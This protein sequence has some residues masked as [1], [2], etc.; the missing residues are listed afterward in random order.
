MSSLSDGLE[1]QWQPSRW[2]LAGYGGFQLLALLSLWQ[3]DL[4]LWALVLG[5]LFCVAHALWVVPRYLSLSSPFAY[6]GLR[7]SHDGWQVYSRAAGW[8]VIEL[9]ADSLALPA[10]ILLRFRLLGQ[11][12]VR[13]LCIARD[14]LS[15]DQHRR[16][17]VRLKFSRN[18][19]AAAR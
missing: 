6:R 19:W 1:C 5:L 10:I 16:L 7:C 17:R 14:S 12:R 15:R 4:P 3:V 13:S 2:L 18:R 11:R 9:H 8:Q